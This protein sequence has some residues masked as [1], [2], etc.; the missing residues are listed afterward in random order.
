M[1]VQLNAPT[2][3]ACVTQR[4]THAFC[5][6]TD[7]IYKQRNEL[8]LITCYFQLSFYTVSVTLRKPRG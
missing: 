2:Q 7:G 5:V 4:V 3:K 8:V 6:F 1:G